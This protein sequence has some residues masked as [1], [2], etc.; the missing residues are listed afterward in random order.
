MTSEGELP[1]SLSTETQRS[2]DETKINPAV[3]NTALLDEI[4][5]GIRDILESLER[6]RPKGRIWPISRTVSGGDVQTEYLNP[7]WFSFHLVND[8]PDALEF[9]VNDLKGPFSVLPRGE[10]I[11]VDMSEGKI[12]V[13]IFRA[14]NN[15]EASFRVYG[16]Y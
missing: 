15:G 14:Q 13:L 2:P 12:A 11:D 5:S 1:R 10:S 3:L 7:Y 4:S 16:V 6:T 9:M 8:G